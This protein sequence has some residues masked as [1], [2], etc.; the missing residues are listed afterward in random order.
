[1]IG[2][3]QMLVQFSKIF[4][5]TSLRKRPW[6]T[7]LAIL[8][9]S[10]LSGCATEAQRHMDS[11]RQATELGNERGRACFALVRANQTYLE[12]LTFFP[13][14]DSEAM[15]LA[16]TL[17][18]SYATPDQA[19]TLVALNRDVQACRELRYV[20]WQDT[21]PVS[22]S[23]FRDGDVE[24]N[25]IYAGLVRRQISWGD[26]ASRLQKTA[27]FTI[28]R[29]RKNEANMRADAE[30]SHSAELGRRAV[31]GAAI[32]QSIAQQ[33]M[34]NSMNRPRTTNCTGFGNSV[35]CTSY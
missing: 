7:M 26:A 21:D 5:L 10:S 17:N 29:V 13:V 11:V 8:L 23:I 27:R 3:G 31:I 1:M 18:Q 24:E 4:M 34:I 22:V 28:A 25:E 14:L 33:Q 9:V 35:N 12:V 15:P 16:T 6:P 32:Q 2:V 19:T 30:Q 20:A